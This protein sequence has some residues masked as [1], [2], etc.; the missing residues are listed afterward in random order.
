MVNVPIIKKVAENMWKGPFTEF[1]REL[2]FP[3]RSGIVYNIKEFLDKVNK[4]NGK[5]NVY[6]SLYSFTKLKADGKP[7][8]DTAKIHHLFFDLDN[9]NYLRNAIKLDQYLKRKDLAHT[10]IFSGGGI[11]I[12]VAVEPTILKNKKATILNAITKI[13]DD[14]GLKIGINGDSD[15]DGHTV[16]NI[17]Q[18]VRVPCTFNIKRKKFCIPLSDGYLYTDWDL[19]TLYK[20]ALKDPINKSLQII[21]KNMIDL[22]N[23]DREPQSIYE[24]PPIDYS[25]VGIDNLND[26]KFL[27]CIKNLLAKKLIKHR[28]RYIVITYFKEIGLPLADSIILLRKYLSPKTFQHCV[29]EE[30]QP[31]WIY[32]RSDLQFPSCNKI[33]EE[34]LCD[35]TCKRN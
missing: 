8:Y 20:E 15:L 33:K 30:R 26:E 17:A 5:M 2:G 22:S 16:G 12:Y 10:I 29:N 32:R 34:D 35:S 25:S 31:M 9:G 7:D 24:M 6:T 4:Y 11:H 3:I 14:I 27:P 28:E 18:L 21:G 1:P 13:A 23:Y 19:E